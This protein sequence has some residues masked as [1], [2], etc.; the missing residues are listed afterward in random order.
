MEEEKKTAPPPLFRAECPLGETE[1]YAL[2][3]YS[4]RKVVIAMC[5]AV[6]LLC[7][8]IAVFSGFSD[9]DIV[10]GTALLVIG[11]AVSAALFFILP[12]LIRRNTAK[13]LVYRG[14][15]NTFTVYGDQLEIATAQSGQTV[16]VMRVP[17]ASLAKAAAYKGMLLLY[18][19]GA[20]ALIVRE[21]SFTAGTAE[22]F[23][24]FCRSHGV[25][26]S[27]KLKKA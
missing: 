14:A 18:L 21:N 10:Y 6:F 16:S 19:N 24:S 27:G 26:V 22:E 23:L 17:V 4:S 1:A 15:V 5:A 20:Q 2:A 3:D 9:G 8:V 12:R 25:R 13:S 7:A 11:A